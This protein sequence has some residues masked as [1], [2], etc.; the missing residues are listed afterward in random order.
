[1]TLRPMARYAPQRIQA[2]PMPLHGI[3]INAFYEIVKAVFALLFL[4]M[5]MYPTFTMIASFVEEKETRVREVLRMMGVDNTSILVSWFALYVMLF[6]VLNL[7]LTVTAGVSVFA[8]TDNTVLFIFLTLY[9]WSAISFA[10]FIHVFFDKARTGGIAGALIFNCCYFV[11]AATFD[12]SE[13]NVK[14]D[15]SLNLCLL[16]PAAFAYGISLLC[17]LEAVNQGAHWGTLAEDT[18]AGITL[19]DVFA[20]L[21]FDALLYGTVRARPGRLSALSVFHSKN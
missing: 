19:A 14:S 3:I 13:G 7:L 20:M 5:Y 18:G 16:S 4:L 17:N 10:Y 9:S 12:F 6:G 8:Y 1:M 2:V 21:L 11:Y 15:G